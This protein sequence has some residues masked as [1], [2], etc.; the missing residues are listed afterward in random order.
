MDQTSYLI[1]QASFFV[2]NINYLIKGFYY[3]LYR[4]NKLYL[5]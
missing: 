3:K 5:C 1:L 2:K 4:H